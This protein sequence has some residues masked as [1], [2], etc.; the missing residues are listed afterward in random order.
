M[1]RILFVMLVVLFATGFLHGHAISSFSELRACQNLE[2][3]VSYRIGQEGKGIPE[4][5]DELMTIERMKAGMVKHRLNIAKAINTFALVPGAPVIGSRNG[6]S[7]DYSGHRLFLISRNEIVAES[8]GSGRCAILVKPLE[9][10]DRPVRVI[11]CFVPEETA[12]IILEGM[13]EFDPAKQPLAFDDLTLF[14]GGGRRRLDQSSASESPSAGVM[15]N[16]QRSWFV[17]S[18]KNWSSRNVI[19]TAVV[20][21]L[22][23]GILWWRLTKSRKSGS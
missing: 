10:D 9:L 13:P 12:K 18:P 8:L 21:L 4:S 7:R 19:V 6:I 17:T 3:D 14:E 5:W 22:I 23:F 2:L 1:N 20:L 16:S 11:S 15:K